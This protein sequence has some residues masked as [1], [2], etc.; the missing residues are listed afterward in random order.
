MT[1]SICWNLLAAYMKGTMWYRA[2]L[3]TA[4]TPWSGAYGSIRA[5]ESFSAGAMIWATAH[6][7][8]FTE[9]GWSYLA[10]GTGA[11]TGSGF[12]QLGG[13]YVTIKNF[14]T[15]D[16]SIIIEKM[17]RNQSFCV[18]PH[19]REFET[20]S[21]NATFLLGGELAANTTTLYLWRSHWAHSQNDTTVEFEQQSPVV[22]SN[23]QFSLEILVDSVYTLTTLNT[24]QKGAHS[25][26]PNPALF[27]EIHVDDFSTCAVPSN[28]VKL[29][30][31]YLHV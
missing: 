27:P 17:S 11:G 21:E 15:G 19:V 12:L 20:A 4:L 5:Q 8:Q 30:V 22:I 29:P 7:T 13:S 9:P 25:T 28:P 14:D 6:T 24:G 18:R 1:S 31:K 23:G 10:N 3:M 2:G 26:P 16:F